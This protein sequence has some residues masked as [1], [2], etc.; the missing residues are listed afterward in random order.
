M[1]QK[2]KY[3]KTAMLFGICLYLS[4]CNPNYYGIYYIGK[5]SPSFIQKPASE[6]DNKKIFG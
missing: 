5:L 3:V 6:E 2:I 1:Y 4:S